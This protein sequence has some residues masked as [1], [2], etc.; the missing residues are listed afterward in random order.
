MG[1]GVASGTLR[2]DFID[3]T[4]IHEHTLVAMKKR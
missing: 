4:Y 3:S 1:G 2:V